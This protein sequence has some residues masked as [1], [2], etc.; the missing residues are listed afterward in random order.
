MDVTPELKTKLRDKLGEMVPSG[1]DTS[2]SFFSDDQIAAML[3]SAATINHA[4][5]DGWE[6]KVAHWANLVTVVDGASSR[7]LTK[8]MEHGEKMIKYYTGKISEGPDSI[9][10]RTR[11]GKIV[12]Q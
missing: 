2:D 6:T 9:N 10:T 12:R 4:I 3:T 1:G 7:E 5:L 8:L 11:I